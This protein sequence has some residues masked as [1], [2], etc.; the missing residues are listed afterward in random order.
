MTMPEVDEDRRFNRPHNFTL[1]ILAILAIS[2]I[3]G[4]YLYF[5]GMDHYDLLGQAYVLEIVQVVLLL[6]IAAEATM[7]KRE[8]Q[9]I[10]YK[11]PEVSTTDEEKKT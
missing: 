5:I 8:V 2:Q 11:I 4:G 1:L 3:V 9:V 7:S 6:F 10:P